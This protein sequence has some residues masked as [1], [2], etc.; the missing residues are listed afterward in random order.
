M[1]FILSKKPQTETTRSKE[2][3]IIA[4]Q[5]ITLD[6]VAKDSRKLKLLYTLSEYGPIS[7]KTVYN[8]I[9]ELKNK[10]IDLNYEFYTIAKNLTSRDLS[11][12]L[13]S[14]KY[15]GLV[16]VD[17]RKRIVVS[18]LGK[19]FLNNN[20]G[21]IPEEERNNIR[22]IINEIKPKLKATDLEVEAKLRKTR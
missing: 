19:E 22:T 1:V 7:E 13:L 12:D 2:V 6:D 3:K 8:L 5:V 18:T 21:K 16:E 17:N 4:R 15:T 14:L 11:N 20:I 9:Y 10:G